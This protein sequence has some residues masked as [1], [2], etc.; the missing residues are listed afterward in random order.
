[1]GVQ[2]GRLSAGLL[3]TGSDLLFTGTTG[4][5]GSDPIDAGYLCA[6]DART[7]EVLWKFGLAGSIQ[8]PPITY[9][10]GGKQYIAVAA[11]DTLFAFALR[12]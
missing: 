5:P 9:A 12:Q 11:N 8:G 6:L 1:M 2:D 4:D 7:G 10:I 3:T